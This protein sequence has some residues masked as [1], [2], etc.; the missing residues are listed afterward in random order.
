M[1]ENKVVNR[2]N[3]TDA[4]KGYNNTNNNQ[5]SENGIPEKNIVTATNY[6]LPVNDYM[7]T[8]TR[9]T[10]P[11]LIM[12]HEMVDLPSKGIH[13]Q[14]KLT[15]IAVEYMTSKDEDVLTTPSLIENNTVFEVL[16]RRKIKSPGVNQN[17][18]LPGDRNAVLLFLRTSSYGS[19]YH[20]QV[21]DP[22]TN[23]PFAAT[24][25]LTKLK[26]KEITKKP[27]ENGYYSVELPLSK[28][29]VVFRLLTF[30]EDSQIYKQAESLREAYNEEVS[31]YSTLKLK[32]SIYSINGRTE[33]DYINKFVDV[34]RALDAFTI[35]KE[36]LNVSPDIDMSYEFTTSDNYKFTANLSIGIDF[37][38]PSI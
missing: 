31:S 23:K 22:R 18:L 30:G 10:D 20:V 38:F 13:Y 37:F 5:M 32:A 29:T 33:R 27:D 3:L 12:S 6:K 19:E 24:V 17:D 9:E 28:K 25:D 36:I 11:D 26:F 4:I 8:L 7:T 14:N 35:R 16:L 34:M 2:L 15:Q 21:Y 1:E